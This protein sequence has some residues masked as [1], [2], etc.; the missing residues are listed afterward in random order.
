MRWPYKWLKGSS[1]S[2]KIMDNSYGT[3]FGMRVSSL[4]VFHFAWPKLDFYQKLCFGAKIMNPT[5]SSSTPSASMMLIRHT[6]ANYKANQERMPL[7]SMTEFDVV[8]CFFR[9]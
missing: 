3:T 2:L 4:N 9:H 6:H 5:W 8:P 7:K 1:V